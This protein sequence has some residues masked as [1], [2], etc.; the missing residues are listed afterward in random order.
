[1]PLFKVSS[2]QVSFEFKRA[3]S[4]FRTL[5]LLIFKGFK[6]YTLCCHFTTLLKRVG[7]K[8]VQQT[9]VKLFACRRHKLQCSSGHIC[10]AW[11]LRLAGHCVLAKSTNRRE[12]AK[13]EDV[14]GSRKRSLLPLVVVVY[15]LK[16]DAINQS[17]NLHFKCAFNKFSTRLHCCCHCCC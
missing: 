15:N 9:Q 6:V 5:Q 4:L 17:T 2:Q 14:N 10:A 8:H 12:A 3:Q 1:L 11:P 7:L 13:W 16:A